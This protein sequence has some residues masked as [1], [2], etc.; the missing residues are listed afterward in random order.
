[1]AFVFAHLV[2]GDYQPIGAPTLAAQALRVPLAQ[3][4]EVH[5][6]AFT[7]AA[8]R[9]RDR[10]ECFL[11]RPVHKGQ[12]QFISL[13][14]KG[15]NERLGY[16]FPLSTLAEDSELLDEWPAN[17]A[18][19]AVETLLETE[20]ARDHLVIRELQEITRADGVSISAVLDP[21]L[22]IVVIG[23]ENLTKANCTVDA[24]R[25]MIQEHGIRILSARSPDP[26]PPSAPPFES[27]LH[28]RQCS[29]D[30][31]DDLGQFCFLI[32]IAEQQRFL[33]ARFLI[34]YQ[35]VEALIAR[36]YEHAVLAIVS[37]PAMLRNVWD[38]RDELEK[39][40]S[41]KS[42]I[43][44]LFSDYLDPKPIEFHITTEDVKNA[45]LAFLLK[46]DPTVTLLTPPAGDPG[47]VV[48]VTPA[49]A[50]Q[51]PHPAAAAPTPDAAR[52]ESP[53][54]PPAP[55]AEV[56]PG[57]TAEAPPATQEPVA[58]PEEVPPAAPVVGPAAAPPE[59]V[60]PPPVP[61]AAAQEPT[62]VGKVDLSQKAWSEILYRCRNLVVHRQWQIKSIPEQELTD[63]C[64]AL[65][66]LYYLTLSSFV[67]PNRKP[68]SGT[69]P[70]EPT[71]AAGGLH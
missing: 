32:E 71:I 10:Y 20:L 1:M 51:P 25:L 15:T 5:I 59:S 21:D 36:L 66:R 63:V 26:N 57:P 7:V 70:T 35:I 48:A 42:R 55:V 24:I 45:C 22:G 2:P 61:T 53:V 43:N 27:R 49:P 52:A 29:A 14:Q 9:P 60:A 39:I 58:A 68:A 6:R 19:V 12:Q 44:K 47:G 46:A 18:H 41:E 31:R 34:L 30:V 4:L 64:S 13:V 8:P 17:F 67:S 56:A 62:T 28:I 69:V 23:K 50:P 38:L 54:A 37:D 33:P 40:S 65:E 3:D 16:L 11:V